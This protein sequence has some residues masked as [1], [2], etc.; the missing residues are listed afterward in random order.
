[1]KSS[2]IAASITVAALAPAALLTPPA[3]A[4]AQESGAPAARQGGHGARLA[5]TGAGDTGW[6]VGTAG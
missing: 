4:A 2:R 3:F 1:M 6:I 5:A